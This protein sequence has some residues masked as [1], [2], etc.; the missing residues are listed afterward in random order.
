MQSL[1]EENYLKA[2][3]LISR[4]GKNE[5]T[6][7]ELA[8]EMKTK[9]SSVTEMLKRLAK[10]NLVKYEKYQGVTLTSSGNKI[11]LTIVRKHRLW[12]YFLV[13]KLGFTWD[14]VH[15][16]AEQLEHIQS[17]SLINRLDKFLD[18]PRFD[19]HGDPIPGENGNFHL[20]SFI[21]LNEL[22]TGNSAFVMGVKN[23]SPEFL[24]YLSKIKI[25][26]GVTV[27]LLKREQFDFSIIIMI[28]N[29]KHTLSKE[30]AMN[31]LIK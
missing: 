15:E 23:H 8:D 29:K 11:A 21:T 4:F 31:V 16:V 3:C 19:P 5:V 22:K 17:S 26:P 24:Q 10:K 6:T 30:V 1:S 9:P 7:N 20:G 2:I 12:E 18:Y 14:Q 28:E 13:E 27:K 25:K